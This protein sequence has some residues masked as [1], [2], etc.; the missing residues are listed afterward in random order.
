MGDQLVCGDARA[1][2]A[3]A[4][5][6]RS[7]A[8]WPGHP[9]SGFARRRQVDP[10]YC[11]G[12]LR[13]APALRRIR[14]GPARGWTAAPIA[15]LDPAEERVDRGN[16]EIPA[17]GDHR[18]VLPEYP[19]RHGCA[20]RPPIDSINRAQE[21]ARPRWFVFPRWE[22][23]APLTLEPLPKSQAFLMVATN[24]FNYEVL[25]ETAFRL[26][27]EMVRSCDP[28][29]WSTP[30]STKP[31]TRSTPFLDPTMTRAPAKPGGP[32]GF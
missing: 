11:T 32:S 5:F 25:D 18:S 3:D 12:S 31:S 2:S 15:T 10:L 4:A 1:S 20:R 17:G 16:Q 28:I 26:V 29:R 8:Q 23:G 6:G 19:Q 22:A 14:P 27:T 13:M 24:A 30:I 21:P 9:V 7:R